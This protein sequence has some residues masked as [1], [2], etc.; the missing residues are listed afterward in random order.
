[1]ILSGELKTELCVEWAAWP[2][3][4]RYQDSCSYFVRSHKALSNREY[5]RRMWVLRGLWLAANVLL[6]CRRELGHSTTIHAVS[7]LSS[8]GS[9]RVC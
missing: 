1:M 3:E 2:G 6:L 4:G 5:W 8:H 9:N 7:S